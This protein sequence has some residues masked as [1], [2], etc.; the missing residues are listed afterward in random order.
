MIGGILLVLA[1]LLQRAFS[2]LHAF[3][4]AALP[5]LCIAVGIAVIAAGRGGEYLGKT[6]PDL[7][8]RR[9][10]QKSASLPER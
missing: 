3:M 9:G 4:S 5:W 8:K 6:G 7:W 2:S 10:L 1:G